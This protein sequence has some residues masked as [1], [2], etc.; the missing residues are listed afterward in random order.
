MHPGKN[1]WNWTHVVD[2]YKGNKV[3]DFLFAFL[4]TN[5][6]LKGVYSK[7]VAPKESKFFSFRATLAS[8]VGGVAK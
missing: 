5:P 2:F 8:E 1:Y 3:Y 7:E 4:Y 6:F